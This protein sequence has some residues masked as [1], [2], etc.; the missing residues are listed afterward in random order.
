MREI[1]H[2]RIESIKRAGICVLLDLFATGFRPHY[3]EYEIEKDLNDLEEMV[4]QNWIPE[5]GTG[6]RGTTMPVL[7]SGIERMHYSFNYD[8][9]EFSKKQAKRYFSVLDK[10]R[11]DYKIRLEEIAEKAKRDKEE[12]EKEKKK[13]YE[14]NPNA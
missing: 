8:K 13:W 4:Q 1:G 10:T 2:G 6:E 7:Q 9:S 12:F 5:P 3:P 14:E 11:L